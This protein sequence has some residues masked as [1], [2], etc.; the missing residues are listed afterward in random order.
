MIPA[1][2][3]KSFA[4]GSWDRLPVEAAETLL[5]HLDRCPRCQ[6]KLETVSDAGDTLLESLR[7]PWV[8]D[9]LLDEPQFQEA[10]ARAKAISDVASKHSQPGAAGALSADVV[11]EL[12]EYQLLE[13]LGEGGMGT[14]YKALHTRLDRVVALKVL[15]E[16]ASTTSERSP[17]SSGR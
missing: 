9:E 16:G 3:A 6:A 4:T 2:G 5:A 10:M 13:K 1:P 8:R 11:G 14:V 15:P 7:R 12:G 17:G